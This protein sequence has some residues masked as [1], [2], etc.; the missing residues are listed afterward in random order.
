MVYQADELYESATEQRMADL[1]ADAVARLEEGES[2]NAILAD[3]PPELASDLRGML[4]I[5]ESLLALQHAPL[6]ARNSTRVRARRTEFLNQ[7]ALEQTR[8]DVVHPDVLPTTPTYAGYVQPLPSADPNAAGLQRLGARV[9][10]AAI[11]ASTRP[12]GRPAAPMPRSWLQRLADAFTIGRLRLMPLI[13]TL[14]LALTAAL[15]LARV[16]QASLPGDLTYPLKSWV[17]M[18]NLSLAAPEARATASQQAAELIQADIAASAVRAQERIGAGSPIVAPRES[19]SLLFD[20]YE[21]RLLKFGDIRVVPSWQPDP[22][23]PATL[24]MNITGDLRPGAL[25]WLT[26]QILPGQGDLVQGVSA[27]VQEGPAGLPP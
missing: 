4:L 15:G 24:P 9:P 23:Q 27:D 14:T 26:M 1:F 25:V 6:P 13:I 8:Q 11:G 21:G 3:L 18:M 12:A 22:N 5:S 20:G 16:T 7:I 10:N 17:K 19:V 2:I